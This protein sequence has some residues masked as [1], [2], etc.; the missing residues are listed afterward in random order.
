M[1]HPRIA[2][3]TARAARG[4]DYDMP[5]LLAALRAAS[6]DVHEVDWDD[7]TVDWSRFD[8]ALLR[9][10]WDYFDRLPA[11]LAWAER[12]SQVARLLNPLDVIKWN[13][14]KHYVDDLART[15]VPVVPSMFVEPGGNAAAIVDALLALHPA[16][17]DIVVKPAVGAGSRDA[18]RHVRGDRDAIVAHV[19]RLLDKNR[20]VL[21]QPYLDRVDEHGETAL[22]F[23]D[24]VF[25]HAT[26]KGPLLK[27]GEGST[28]GL[29]AEETIE[30]RTPS[31]EELSVA[32]SVLAAMPFGQS[33]LYARV[34][35]IRGDD[36][37]PLLLELELV[38]PSVFVAHADGVAK[39]FAKAILRRIPG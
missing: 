23:F 15:G 20:S 17:R 31:A 34:D 38:E 35:L 7:D 29:Y 14:D 8:L 21:L 30:P 27:R 3:V 11:F 36:G 39:R 26:R 6:A 12:V 4:T 25:S 2:L 9:S 24:G 13:T 33:L 19:R 22:L 32:Q 18:Q 16:A 10:T 28:T 37:S 1:T 5:L